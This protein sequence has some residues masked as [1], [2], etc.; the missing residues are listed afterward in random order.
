VLRSLKSIFARR[1]AKEA[2]SVVSGQ[3]PGQSTASAHAAFLPP[4]QAL[5][6]VSTPDAIIKRF[7]PF[8]VHGPRNIKLL[9]TLAEAY[10]RKMMFDQSLSLYKRAL[11]VMGG[12]NADI[13]HA[14]E[15]TTL[16]K[17]DLELS[18]LDPKAPDHAAQRERLQNQRLDYQWHEMEESH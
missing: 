1:V 18:Q 5:R 17:L 13:E 3:A 9:E 2:P 12:K 16:K 7:E 4:P 11:E 6:E 10:G 15:E 14:I 8:L